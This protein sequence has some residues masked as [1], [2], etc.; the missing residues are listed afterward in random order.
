MKISDSV[1]I[2]HITEQCERIIKITENC[3]LDEFKKNT[4]YQDAVT[5]NIEIIGEAA[6]N[7]S[8]EFAR[9]HPEIEIADMTG[10]RNFLA[11]QYFRV[12]AEIVWRTCVEDIPVLYGKLQNLI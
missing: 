4:T 7:L 9:S 12:D 10:M 8:Q 1:L 6:G 3:A 5:R 2:A 11:H